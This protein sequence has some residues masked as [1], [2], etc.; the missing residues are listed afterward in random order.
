MKKLS[1]LLVL[2]LLVTVGGVYATWNYAGTKFESVSKDL[3]LSI[4]NRET[5]MFSGRIEFHDT[6]V[7]KIDDESVNMAPGTPKYTPGWDDYVTD[8]LG[9]EFTIDFIASDGLSYDAKIQY[10][11][12]IENNSY[13]DP[14]A[15]NVKIFNFT[16]IGGADSNVFLK[17]EFT[18]L[19]SELSKSITWKVSDI[20]N[21]LKVNGD[22]QLDDTDQYDAYEL[23][24]KG[25]KIT[26][27]VSEITA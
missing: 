23:A 10:V 27:T 16:P 24:L 8:T 13:T 14:E 9:G 17:G 5:N 4:T 26:C 12:T 11:F 15:G 19:K 20:Q 7:L 21:Y 3:T 6:L 1:I 18:C 22:F 2:A 25:V